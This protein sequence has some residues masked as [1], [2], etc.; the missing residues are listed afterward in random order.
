MAEPVDCEQ[1]SRDEIRKYLFDL[2]ERHIDNR[3]SYEKIRDN[4]ETQMECWG[5]WKPEDSD[6]PVTVF[7]MSAEGLSVADFQAFYG[8]D[9]FAKNAMSMDSTLRC[10]VL[11]E[12]ADDGVYIMYQH[13]ETPGPNWMSANRSSFAAVYNLFELPDDGGFIHLATSKG[14]RAIEEANASLVDKDVVSQCVIAYNKF[15][16]DGSGVRITTVMSVD[17]AGAMPG[18]AKNQI[19][20]ANSEYPEKLVQELLKR[21]TAQK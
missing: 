11:D 19:A 15:E 2:A 12:K 4:Q 14:N 10:E 1:W 21:K 5:C 20:K 9:A 13:I 7:K 8:P 17:P 3:A 16:P 6:V 18:W